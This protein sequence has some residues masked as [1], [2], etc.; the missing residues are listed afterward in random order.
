MKRENKLLKNI[1]FSIIPL[2]LLLL[3]FEILLRC[4]FF[5]V[6]GDS[7]LAI[8]SGAS[9][10]RRALLSWQASRRVGDITKYGRPEVLLFSSRGKTLLK[11]FEK[12][13][14]KE[15]AELVTDVKEIDSKLIM[16]YIPSNNYRES[17]SNKVCRE[18]YSQLARK[19]GIDYL[20]LTDEFL[21]YPVNMVTLLPENGHLSRYGN[22]LVASKIAAHLKKYRDYRSSF[23]FKERPDVFGDLKPARSDIWYLHPN[24]PYRVVTNNQ[25]LRMKSD[26]VFPK[27]KQRILILGDSYTFGPYLPNEYTYPYFLA[28]EY[29]NAEIINAGVAGYTIMDEVSLF[30]ERAKYVEPDITILQVL[31]NDITDLFYFNRNI[32]DR[33]KRTYTPTESE[34]EFFK[35]IKDAVRS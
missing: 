12:K 6:K 22:K 2:I 7:C 15:F 31:D 8:V 19:Y 28:E 16:V 5:Q 10:C 33:K 24:M 9:K 11:E 14:E 21:K 30:E 23:Q 29:G 13:Y 26:I 18:F 25:G 1:V 32:F 3:L 17:V 20:D 4:V 35:N 34:A 27:E